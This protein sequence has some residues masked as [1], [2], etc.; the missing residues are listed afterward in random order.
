M[1]GYTDTRP[2]VSVNS[3]DSKYHRQV[4]EAINDTRPRVSIGSKC[5]QQVSAVS[6]DTTESARG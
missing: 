3:D 4:P 6:A 1:R 2:R 5:R